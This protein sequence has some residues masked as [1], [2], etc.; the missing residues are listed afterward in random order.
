MKCLFNILILVVFTAK[1]FASSDDPNGFKEVITEE[2]SVQKGLFTVYSKDDQIFFEIPDSLFGRDMLIAS[3]IAKVSDP[4]KAMAGEMRRNPLL[5]HFEKKGVRVMMMV[6]NTDDLLGDSVNLLKNSFDRNYID[7][8]FHVFP[9][10]TYAKDSS[11]LIDVSEFF[12]KEIPMITPFGS[13]GKPGKLDKD[14]SYIEK[15]QV[16]ENN[17]EIQSYFNYTN[18][19]TPFRA[20]LNRSL[21]L[22]PKVPMMPRLGDR[23]INYFTS[24][25]KVFD[26]NGIAARSVDYITR[27]RMEPKSED[28]KKYLS[29]GLVVP[30]K[31]IVVYIDNGIPKRWQKYVKAGIEDWRIAFEAIGFKDAVIAK[32]FPEDSAFNPDQLENTCF[33][34]IP[35]STANAMGLRWTD[36][37]S[38]E[39]LQGEVVWFHDV[40][41]KLHDWR[42]VQ[43]GTVDPESR[44]EIFSDGL[45]GRMIRY[46][47]AHEMGHVLGLK[48]NMRASYS[49]PVDSLR[50]ETFTDIYGTTP[51]IMDYARNNY[52]AQPGDG[53]DSLCPPLIGKYDMFAIKYGYQ[54]LPDIKTPNDESSILNKFFLDVANDPMCRYVNQFAIGVSG[55]PS[56]QSESLGDDAIRANEYGMNNL[57]VVVENLSQWCCK[58]NQG[59]DYLERIYKEVYKQYEEYLKHNLSYIGGVY[60]YYGVEGEGKSSEKPITKIKQQQA[61]KWIFNQIINSGWLLN[62]DVEFRLGNKSNDYFKLQASMFDKLMNG[63]FFQRLETYRDIYNSGEYLSDLGN[64]VW[65]LSSKDKLSDLDMIIQQNFVHNLIHIMSSSDSYVSSPLN[66]KN[67]LAGLNEESLTSAN[68]SKIGFAEHFTLMAAQEQI[69]KA[70]KIVEKQLKNKLYRQHYLLIDRMIE[71]SGF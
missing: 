52:V 61:L 17:I 31:Q 50:S 68:A 65:S 60:Q 8:I 4:T 3:R 46:A 29:G 66:S 20:L 2:F 58:P 24:G 33:R 40:I 18:P 39:I 41:E 19:S 28:I 22:L 1:M 14:A 45:M 6:K 36:P 38:G 43:C 63:F 47:A 44:K 27:F 64:L 15:I 7:P 23:R 56:A 9:V 49:Y 48:H 16:C 54:W 59:Y 30:K 51:S 32:V 42:L 55:D 67:K 37:R 71:K 34:Y 5:F 11:V 26:E 62:K 10:K 13:K 21:V 25:K 53:V 57:K 12:L 69:L 35:K 70:K